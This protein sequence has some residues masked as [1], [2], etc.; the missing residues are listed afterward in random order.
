MS[1]LSNDSFYNDHLYKDPFTIK[2]NFETS[3]MDLF[4]SDTT[5]CANIKNKSRFT[6][7]ADIDRLCLE[8]FKKHVTSKFKE[9]LFEKLKENFSNE[10]D[11]ENLL[12]EKK[13][14]NVLTSKVEEKKEL[15]I[16]IP[17][18]R[19]PSIKNAK[20]LR[21]PASRD[22]KYFGTKAST[23]KLPKIY[24]AEDLGYGAV[25]DLEME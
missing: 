20:L 16:D 7:S 1:M 10:S 17:S 18:P 22:L 2:F 15:K 19:S 23:K 8:L 3:L 9:E 25:F 5:M 4:L 14:K 13:E 11:K 12:D 6:L 24:R 21:S